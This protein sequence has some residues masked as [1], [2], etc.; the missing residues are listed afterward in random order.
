MGYA[1][2]SVRIKPNQTTTTV[3]LFTFF[4]SPPSPLFLRL[5]QEVISTHFRTSQGDEDLSL[6]FLGGMEVFSNSA[7]A[8]A[9][10]ALA[11]IIDAITEHLRAG[12]GSLVAGRL[13][14]EVLWAEIRHGAALCRPPPDAALRSLHSRRGR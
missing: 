12:G 9:P 8:P 11:E 7:P 6:V 3:G 5:P 14:E 10:S 13:R 1:R 2:F 4:T